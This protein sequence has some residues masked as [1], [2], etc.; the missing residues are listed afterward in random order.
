MD[1]VINASLTCKRARAMIEDAQGYNVWLTP[2]G[3]D[4]TLFDMWATMEGLA[5]MLADHVLGTPEDLEGARQFVR[6]IDQEFAKL[7]EALR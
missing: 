5:T 1:I 6:E 3:D 7:Q 4:L 2:E